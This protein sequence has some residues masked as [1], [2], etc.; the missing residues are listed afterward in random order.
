MEENL[1]QIQE[2]SRHARPDVRLEA[3]KIWSGLSLDA[4]SHPFFTK[5]KI[6]NDLVR[7][8]SDSNGEIV[9]HSATTLV[10]LSTNPNFVDYFLGT[11]KS[12]LEVIIKEIRSSGNSQKDLLIKI[13]VNCTREAIGR[14]I[15]LQENTPLFGLNVVRLLHMLE[16]IDIKN[17]QQISTYH[18]LPYIIVNLCQERMGRQLLMEPNRRLLLKYVIPYMDYNI[19]YDAFEPNAP[20]KQQYQIFHQG[21]WDIVRNCCFAINEKPDE[22]FMRQWWKNKVQVQSNETNG[23]DNDDN[24]N[25]NDNDDTNDISSADLELRIGEYFCDLFC[26]EENLLLYE[27]LNPLLGG[28]YS[29]RN[30]IRQALPA[31]LQTRYMKLNK[32]RFDSEWIRKCSLQ[33]LGLLISV[34][35]SLVGESFASVFVQH[36]LVQNLLLPKLLKEYEM[37]EPK[38]DLARLSKKIR[39]SLLRS[40]QVLFFLFF[41]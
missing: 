7:L 14:T 15:V 27:I 34:K 31:R 11:N 30:S 13:L 21:I 35:K 8:L 37:W 26:F 3:V 6:G 5:L 25:D 18:H 16:S 4:Q 23:D 36:L 41:C 2:F 20:I 32:A 1:R 40:S 12:S 28:I 39:K 9:K 29:Y 38:E 19:N 10:N 24:D 17:S 22:K 33:C